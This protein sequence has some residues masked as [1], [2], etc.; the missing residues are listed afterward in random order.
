[1]DLKTFSEPKGRKIAP[2]KSFRTFPLRHSV[3][4]LF[5]RRSS[6]REEAGQYAPINA[7]VKPELLERNMFNP[8]RFSQAGKHL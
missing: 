6:S 4:I 7:L 5:F 2:E 1:M 8:I 3:S